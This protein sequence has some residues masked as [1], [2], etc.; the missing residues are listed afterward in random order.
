VVED[1]KSVLKMTRKILKKYGYNVL[2]V[3]DGDEAV[4]VGEQYEPPI[5]LMVTDVI[6][7][8]MSG[9]E[10]AR[11]MEHM[12]PGMKVLYMSGYTDNA[13]VH[14]GILD[15]DLRYIQKPF[16]P[17]DLAFKVREAIDN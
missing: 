7:P 8:K 9:R 15:E 1:N 6:M 3:Q 4:R 10:V 14:H 11:R 5:H 17:E 13:V 16:T 12:R 2:A